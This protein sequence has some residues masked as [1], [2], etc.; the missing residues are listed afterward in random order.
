MFHEEFGPRGAEDERRD[1]WTDVPEGA[2]MLPGALPDE[3]VGMQALSGLSAQ[4]PY[5]PAVASLNADNDTFDE[6]DAD[7]DALAEQA[8]RAARSA[9]MLQTPHQQSSSSDPLGSW[10]GVPSEDI[11][12]VPTQDQDDL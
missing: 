10:T 4:E 8:D 6:A 11:Y 2:D 12:E 1:F 7:L 9:G 5:S 3:G